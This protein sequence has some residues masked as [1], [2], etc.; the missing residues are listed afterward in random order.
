MRDDQ[1]GLVFDLQELWRGNCDYAVIQ[2]LEQIKKQH[3]RWKT[4]H[5]EV[6]LGDDII[7][8]LIERLKIVLSMQEI[9]HNTRILARCI[10]GKTTKLHFELLPI[11]VDRS[12]TTFTR[13]QILN[14]TANQLHMNK[15]THWYM[16]QRLMKNG[17]LRLYSKTKKL[18]SWIVHGCELWLEGAI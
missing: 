13:Q 5:Y 1:S 10:T 11:K 8:V 18:L 14:H 4:E 6:R 7:A 17:S 3:L 15:S 2:T 12:D 9:L 16:K